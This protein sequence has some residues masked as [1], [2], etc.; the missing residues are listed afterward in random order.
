MTDAPTRLRVGDRVVVSEHFDDA[1]RGGVIALIN[2]RGIGIDFDDGDYC[3]Y[4]HH[5]KP[6]II[7]E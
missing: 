1:R 7:G 4:P 5:R 6:G 2:R 3:F